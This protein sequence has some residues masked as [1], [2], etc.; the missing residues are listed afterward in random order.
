MWNSSANTDYNC[1]I[2]GD[3]QYR[4][5]PDGKW[6]FYNFVDGIYPAWF[7]VDPT[8]NAWNHIALE[9]NGGNFNFYLNGVKIY[10]HSTSMDLNYTV[11]RWGAEDP[12]GGKLWQGYLDYMRMTN[13]ARYNG[14]DFT[15]PVSNADYN[16]A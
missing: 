6:H 2:S 3:F 14:N 13:L 1:V 12:P 7:G 4:N 5:E 15:P 8:E 16:P 11:R 9:R 10:T